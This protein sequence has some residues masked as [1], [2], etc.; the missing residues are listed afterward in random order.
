MKNLILIN[1]LFLFLITVL[2]G[3][4]ISDFE[5]NTENWHSEG[6][7]SY[8]WESGTGNPG[9]CFRVND[10]ATG[11]MNRSYAPVKFLGDWSAA[12]ITDY[13]SADIFL[14]DMGG[15]YVNPNFVFRIVGPGGSAIAIYDPIPSPPH[16]TW[17]T[18]SVNLIESEWFVEYGVWA[19]ILQHVTT[20]IVTMEYISGDEWNLLDNVT[21]SITPIAVPITPVL[22]SDFES[23]LFEGWSVNSSGGASIA[24]T[25]GN[26]GKYLKI[27][28]GSGT[29]IAVP[30]SIYHG[31]WTSL[32]GHNAEIHV[33]YLITDIDGPLYLHDFFVKI[34]GPG[35]EATYPI[36]NSIELAYNKWHSFGIAIE[37]TGWTIVSG[38]WNS[39][40]NFVDDIQIVAEFISGDETVGIDN[41]CISN[42]PPITDFI[43]E[44]TFVFLGDIVQFFDQTTSAPQTWDW[45]FGDSGSSTEVNP[46][47]QYMTPG[48]YTV[49]LTTTNYFG[50]S[51]ETKTEYI[52]VYPVDQCLKF[53]DDFDDNIIH[54]SW[55]FKNGTW[56]ETTGLMKQS[57]N[58]YVTGN[59]LEGCFAIT[60][61]LF[62]ED[63]VVSCDF[64]STDNDIIGF[65]FNYQDEQNMY[66]FRWRLDP[67]YRSLFKYENGVETELATDNVGYN[68][69]DWYYADIASFD[70][71]IV[72]AINGVEIF[73][74]FDDTFT[75]GKV[76]L[77]CW[78]N[79]S[80]YYD[81]FKVECPGAPVELT[82]FL[83]GPFSGTEMNT[84]LNDQNILA[85]N[86]PY[87]NF[88]WNHIGTEGVLSFSNPDVSDWVL[89]DFRDATSASTALPV[90]SV[91]TKAALLLKNGQIISPYGGLPLY[92]NTT[93]NNSLFIV[94]Q[95]RNH[96]GILS[97]NPL[98]ESGGVYTYDFTTPV[99]QAYGTDAQKNLVGGIYGMYAGDG[100][101]NGIVNTNDK[102]NVWSLQAGKK[103]YWSGDFDMNGQVMN[104]DKND[105]WLGNLNEQT[106][107]PD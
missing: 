11:D 62:W 9:G 24:N 72:L 8:Y 43:A 65:V 82:V 19:D 107:V 22:C 95:H 42:L 90:T 14:H 6:D 48:L 88:P 84:D 85:L 52:E 103:G 4:V 63:Y 96:L 68:I 15:G 33:D 91:E 34:A 5:I 30:S 44:K 50:N 101:A 21:L 86:N 55:S 51:T 106:Q 27:N 74:V 54:Q 105:V 38:D 12:T 69:N 76:G 57:S 70:G 46:S 100:D 18:Y 32:D 66:M 36:D 13:V 77:Y 104:Q 2:T 83:E 71:N 25:G 78:G 47:H 79:Q 97:A 10:Y 17:I 37:Q 87:S 92:L 41:F 53:E 20:F 23:G 60:G 80:S 67:L 39:L 26:P 58:H 75:N 35:G 94:I 102:S 45:D 93:I 73:S 16:D 31:D 98:I 61:S 28:D 29:S 89:V 3:Q 56:D 81:S 7:G 40:L 59:Y 1:F 49:S 99:G 64:R